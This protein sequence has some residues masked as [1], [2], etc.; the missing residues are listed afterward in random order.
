MALT[1]SKV[2]QASRRGYYGDEHGLF[3]KVGPAGK[4]RPGSKSW[5]FRYRVGDKLYEMGLG[6]V[7]TVNL[8]EAREAALDYRKALLAFRQG[9]VADHP[10]A[11]KQAARMATKI[12]AAKAMTFRECAEAYIQSHEAG[13]RGGKSEL[14]WRQSL[15]DH[16]FP[17]FGTL[18]VQAIDTALVMKALQPIWT[19][20]TET[21]SRIRGRIEA[22][23]GWATTSGYRTGDNPARWRGHLENLLPQKTKVSV[24]EHYAA[25]PHTEMGEF[26]SALRQRPGEAARALEF[27]I[28]TA[29]R[30]SEVVG[31][32]WDEIDM[33]ARVWTIPASRMKAGKEH[34][35]PLS[36]A[37]MSVLAQLPRSPALVFPGITKHILAQPLRKRAA[38]V[39]GFRS[40]FASWAADHNFPPDV[41]EHALAHAVGTK[42]DRTYQR[43]D[44][45]DRRRQLM[46]AWAAYC[47]R[48]GG[49]EVVPI[50]AVAVYEP[51][52]GR[53][54]ITG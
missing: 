48:V 3:L 15:T 21:A 17:V 42:V 27:A 22:I 25:M 43:S 35:V 31:A 53:R 6:P 13:W 39:H 1:A 8:A 20:K 32:R 5:V 14:Q 38:T 16:V 11:V 24:I 45:F 19:T 7:H 50:R 30:S 18:P 51:A 23:L 2:A 47:G 37:A 12:E 4:K 54:S 52:A 34:R 46:D 36:D 49:G 44:L 29:A 26:M 41:R 10:L 28:L 40:T 33:A 9:K